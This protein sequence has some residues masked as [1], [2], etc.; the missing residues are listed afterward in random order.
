MGQFVGSEPSTAGRNRAARGR[1][2]PTLSFFKASG[3]DAIIET[4]ISHGNVKGYNAKE[5]RSTWDLYKR[6]TDKLPLKKATRDDGRKVVQ[7]LQAQG[8]K[9]AT[10]IKKVGWLNA[11]VNLVI[12]E[13][14]L[15]F[16]PF[17]RIVP[18]NDDE[19]ARLP[20]S[21]ADMK[22]CHGGLGDLNEEDQLLFWFW[23]RQACVCQRHSKSTKNL[24]N[25]TVGTLLSERSR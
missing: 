9:S 10:V 1:A 11:A 20:L 4:Y 3:D 15:Q 22:L 21:E 24:K 2:A 25:E 13:T 18:K 16:N 17:S 8:L 6:L 7:Y 14:K 5:A 19:D 23:H 12:D